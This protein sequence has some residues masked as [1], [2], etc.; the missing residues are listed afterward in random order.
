MQARFESV[1]S[2]F[3]QQFLQVDTFTPTYVIVI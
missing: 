2:Y 3:L 1:A